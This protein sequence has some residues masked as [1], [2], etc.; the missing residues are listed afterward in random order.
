MTQSRPRPADSETY[1]HGYHKAVVAQHASRTASEAAAFVLPRLR[2][3]MN[4]L[5]IGCGPG[6]ITLGLADAVAPGHVTGIDIGDEPIRQARVAASNKGITNVSFEVGSV[7]DLAFPDATFDSVYMHQVLQHLA[8][9]ADALRQASRVL[10]QGGLIAVREVDWGSTVIWPRMPLL[11]RFLQLYHDVAARNGGDADAGRSVRRWL[12]G[13]QFENIELSAS[14]WVFPGRDTTA[15][16]GESWAE[17]TAQSNIA[18]KAIEYKLSDQSE[19]DRIAAAWREWGTDPDAFFAFTHV[20]GIA[21]R[22]S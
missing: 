21:I 7:Y 1:T 10:R 13:A 22:R 11:D 16:Y 14:H 12:N 5:D 19:L 6:S 2:A 15:N 4:L 9:P 8:R 20:E 18:V 3:G 17:R